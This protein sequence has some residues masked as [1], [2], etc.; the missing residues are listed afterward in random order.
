MKEAVLSL[1]Q[2]NVSDVCRE[3]KYFA[4]APTFLSMAHSLS[5]RMVMYRLVVWLILFRASRVVPQVN[6][7]SPATA[8]T[9]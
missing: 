6:A 9:W 2:E 8:T 5:F 1:N 4:S 7:A 3:L